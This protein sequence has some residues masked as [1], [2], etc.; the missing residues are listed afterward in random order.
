MFQTYRR[1][2]KCAGW[3][4]ILFELLDILMMI[5]RGED[6]VNSISGLGS[7]GAIVGVFLLR[8]NLNELE[9]ITGG[10]NRH[11]LQPQY[12]QVD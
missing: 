4:L 12:H 11:G 9:R 10:G 3:S 8:G 2:L 6:G 1:R 7:V 5:Y